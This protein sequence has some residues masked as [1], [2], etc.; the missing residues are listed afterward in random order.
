MIT[1]PLSSLGH[2]TNP[3]R[4]LVI[5]L[6]LL[7]SLFFGVQSAVAQQQYYSTDGAQLFY[8]SAQGEE[9]YESQS[10]YT[11]IFPDQG[12]FRFRAKAHTF[13]KGMASGPAYDRISTVLNCNGNPEIELAGKL[14][15]GHSVLP[16]K[17][18]KTFTVKGYLKIGG[19]QR[20]HAFQV[21]LRNEGKRVAYYVD[22]MIDAKAWGLQTPN[23]AGIHHI[24][25][26]FSN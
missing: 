4:K 15:D 17:P 20:P 5:G 1:S 22:T 7:C 23:S 6:F 10:I 19:V 26:I 16:G 3:L 25:L 11:A 21:R 12:V 14:P 24:R 8:T 9:R 13:L 18:E 2:R